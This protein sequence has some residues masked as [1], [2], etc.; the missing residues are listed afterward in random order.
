MKTQKQ[1]IIIPLLF[2]LILQFCMV[3]VY[4]S[5]VVSSNQTNTFSPVY[6]KG[7]AFSSW[8]PEAF[9]D[10]ISDESLAQLAQTNTEWIS[11]CFSWYQSSTT[12]S[13]IAL[14]PVKSPTV[15][16]LLHAI[17]TAHSLGLKVMLKPMVE[18]K[19]RQEVLS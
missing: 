3:P 6:Q 4:C 11:L 2:V 13:D 12:S 5:S 14:D 18:P 15:E 9:N 7:F 8:A 17:E 19:E 10:P 16:S 1:L